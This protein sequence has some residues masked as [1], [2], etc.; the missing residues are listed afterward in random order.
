MNSLL[1]QL[2]HGCARFWPQPLLANRRERL[3][4]CL[5]AALGLII[6]ELVCRYAFG[7]HIP[8]LLAPM[9]ASAVLLFA[10]P[11]SP[12]AQP[13]SIVGGNLVASL[14]GVSCAQLIPDN[15]VAAG[16][17]VAIS[18][19]LMFPLR[20]VHPPSG[21]VAITAV[22]GGPVITQLGYG[23]VF[24]PVLINSLLLTLVALVFNNACKRRYPHAVHP[25]PAKPAI[26]ISEPVQPNAITQQDI[27]AALTRRG[28]IVDIDEEDLLEI[29]KAAQQIANRNSLPQQEIGIKRAS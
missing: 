19:A 1:N 21:A 2:L 24:Y 4:S 26:N 5:G 16:I 17:A 3:I 14:V 11:A 28:E 23:F 7:Q 15:N 6:T 13:W 9:G 20:C 27:H 12:L 18:I 29:F 10:I 25:H 8:W 22:L